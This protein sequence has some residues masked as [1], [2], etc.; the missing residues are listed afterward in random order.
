MYTIT[1]NKTTVELTLS[2]NDNYVVQIKSLSE[3]GL[4]E[5]SEPIHIH[6]LSKCG[7]SFTLSEPL[8]R[9][10]MAIQSSKEHRNYKPLSSPFMDYR[11]FPSFFCTM[12]E[13]PTFL[14]IHVLS[15]IHLY[16]PLIVHC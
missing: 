10:L 5:G 8:H 14:E 9:L 1:T 6:Q 12:L 7:S 2:P 13:L 4:G 3:G 15:T 16:Q 11:L